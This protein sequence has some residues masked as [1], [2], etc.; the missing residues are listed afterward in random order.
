MR[1]DSDEIHWAEFAP[2]PPGDYRLLVEGVGESVGLA[3]PVHGL[4]CV[5]DD[6]VPD[7]DPAGELLP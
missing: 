5:V 3:D 4:V 1:R 2:L 7:V 6:A